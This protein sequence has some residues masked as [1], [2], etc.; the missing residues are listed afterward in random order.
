VG[1]KE[2]A[3]G[4]AGCYTAPVALETYAEVFE[5]AGAVDRLE[6]F[7]SIYGARFYG[8]PRNTDTVTLRREPWQVPDS[9]PF[10]DSVVVPF[11]AGELVHWQLAA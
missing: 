6:G 5:R 8:L 11:R 1:T 2:A 4:C 7:A 3:C 9:L 10:G